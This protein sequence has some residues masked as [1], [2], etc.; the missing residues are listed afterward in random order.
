MHSPAIEASAWNSL[1]HPHRDARLVTLWLRLFGPLLRRL[2][3][4]RRRLLLGLAA[5]AFAVRY[6]LVKLRRDDSMAMEWGTADALVVAALLAG[7][8]CACYAAAR[9]FAD[10]P[11][12]VRTRPLVC[13][14]AGFWILLI[15]L[16]TAG[17]A[18]PALEL[19]LA[20]CAL[21]MPFL[22]WRLSYLVQTAQ[23]GRLS[24]TGF[25]DHAMYL[26][27]AWGGTTTPYGKGWDYLRASEAQDE[28]ALARSQIAG[29]K[30]IWL[31]L[32]W[33]VAYRTLSALVFGAGT[34]FG[35]DL[36]DLALG[37][38]SMGVILRAEPGSF[39]PWQAWLAL[40]GE[41]ILQVL[42]LAASGHLIIGYARLCGFYVFRNTYK[43]L[44]AE[45]VVEFWNRYYYYFKELLLQFFFFPTF[46]R[47]FK[48]H[49]RLRLF[50]AVFASAFL[51]NL[52][53]HV[54]QA[55]SL[56]RADWEALSAMLVPRTLY[57][58]LLALGI[59]VSMQ[60]ERLRP[61]GRR[62]LGR[63]LLAIFGVW[64]FYAILSIP[65][66]PRVPMRA[67][68]DYLLGLAGIA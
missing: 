56:V 43:P 54:V 12:F 26:W 66:F 7:Y 61:A 65:H 21:A 52:Y 49:P 34:V 58:F 62:P 55:E 25:L 48:Q 40:Y 16:W 60:R 64:T 11:P 32:L 17:P 47:H 59:Y 20:G 23:R 53:Y 31:G 24:G 33:H 68:F 41:L 27:P 42:K 10:L 35:R 22:L 30:L 3:P 13:L 45:S 44:L 57:C 1:R 29:I 6:P 28:E 39:A 18:S 46:A 15:A 63:R 67:R 19:I 37:L 14:H 36:G 2:T 9:R 51:G 38:P 4:A 8:A 5:L 50:A